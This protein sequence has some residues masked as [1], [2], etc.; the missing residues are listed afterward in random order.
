MAKNPA[1]RPPSFKPEYSEQAAKLCLLGATDAELA[2]FFSVA[3]RTI[4]RWQ[5]QYPEFC[6][7]LKVAKAEAD[8]R[9]ERSLYNRAVG[10]DH[11]AVKIFMPAGAKK[12]VYAKFVEH[13]PPDTTAMIFWLKNR[14]QD[15]W[16]DVHRHEH[17]KPG[18]FSDLTDEELLERIGDIT[19]EAGGSRKAGRRTG[20]SRGTKTLQ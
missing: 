12:P 9:V 19:G 6:Q 8:T 13:V 2:D 1:H 11:E 5:A 3:T 15:R 16:R 4:Y 7:S 17:G 18:D 10:Y 20:P 14:Q